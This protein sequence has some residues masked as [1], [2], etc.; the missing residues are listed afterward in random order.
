MTDEPRSS[1]DRLAGLIDG[2]PGV[3]KTR[4]STF[5]DVTPML[6]DVSTYIIQTYATE[7]GFIAF[8]QTIDARGST[9]VVLPAKVTSA[10]YRQRDSLIRQGRKQ[11]GRDRWES[12]TDEQRERAVARLREAERPTTLRRRRPSA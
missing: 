6:G 2:L 3:R 8:V 1:F 10:L 7:D 9:R 4:P 5:A 11:R 12:L